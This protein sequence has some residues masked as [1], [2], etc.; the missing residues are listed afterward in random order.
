MKVTNPNPCLVN[1]LVDGDYVRIG[2]NQT[3]DVPEKAVAALLKTGALVAEKTGKPAAGGKP[4]G[5][6]DNKG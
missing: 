6:S 4:E 2:P 5:E 1:V 3:A